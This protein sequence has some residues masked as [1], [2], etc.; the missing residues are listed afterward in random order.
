MDAQVAVLGEGRQDGVGGGTDADLEGRAVGDPL[1]DE[2]GDT[3]VD[4]VAGDLDQRPVDLGPA[5]DLVTWS[6][7]RPNVRG[8]CELASRKNRALPMNDAV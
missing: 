1:S 4:V 6:W 8:I 5:G 7:L 2:R 3:V